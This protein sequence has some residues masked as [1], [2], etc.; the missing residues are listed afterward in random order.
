[1]AMQTGELREGEPNADINTTP[2]IDVMLVLP[3]MLIVTLPPQRHA[4]KLDAPLPCPDCENKQAPDPIRIAVDF[5][6]AMKWNGVSA[7]QA[8]IDRRLGVESRRAP[9]PE[10]HV[11]AHRL[12]RYR[13]VAHVMAVAQ[14]EGL[15]R[16]GVV[17]G[18]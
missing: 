13:N 16:M 9:L 5:D 8:E 14:R 6:G 10:V 4:V 2:L 12:A 7:S 3:I 18:T 1:M 15:K 17:G 11:E